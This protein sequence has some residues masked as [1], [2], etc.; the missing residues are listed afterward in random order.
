MQV[1]PLDFLQCDDALSEEQLQTANREYH[2]WTADGMYP[3]LPWS[4]CVLDSVPHENIPDFGPFS[5]LEAPTRCSVPH[6]RQHSQCTCSQQ[7]SLLQGTLLGCF[8][9]ALTMQECLAFGNL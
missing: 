4:C 3:M 6:A 7:L 5:T 1:A 9:H 8:G 2:M